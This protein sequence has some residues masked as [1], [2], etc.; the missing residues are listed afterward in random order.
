MKTPLVLTVLCSA[1]IASAC[2]DSTS[3][4]SF[5]VSLSLTTGSTSASANRI[6]TVRDIT[7]NDGISELVMTRV[8]VVL[9]EIELERVSAED[10]L[11]DDDCEEFEAGPVLLELPLD[12]SV[13][14]AFNIDVPA[15]SYD[16]LEVEIH[17][18]DTMDD[19]A[20]IAANPDFEDVSIRV[21]GTF[22]GESFVYLTDLNGEQEMDLNPPLEVGEAANVNV[23]LLLDVATW[24]RDGSNN[25]VDPV[26][27]N[28]G[29]ANENLVE[30]NIE[31]S[32]DAFEDDDRDGDDDE[33]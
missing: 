23:T 33:G 4:E 21:E 25:L 17:K 16:E 30:D 5:Q 26:T 31:A 24:F 14:T 22:D 27:A 10:C 29:G 13:S 1:L 7:L 19:A 2:S 9:R 12:G 18:P 3:P 32:I 15:D 11:G 6:T 20:F 8:A 28:E